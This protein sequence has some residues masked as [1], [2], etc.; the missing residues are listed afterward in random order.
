[1]E[2]LAKVFCHDRFAKRIMVFLGNHERDVKPTGPK[3]WNEMHVG[4]D[5]PRMHFWGDI[6]MAIEEG[7]EDGDVF[8]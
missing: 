5:L 4:E 7:D 3:A 1:M 8:W 2:S 6:E